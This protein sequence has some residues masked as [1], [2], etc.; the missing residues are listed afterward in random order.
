MELKIGD[1]VLCIKNYIDSDGRIINKIG[2]KYSVINISRFHNNE[3]DI[4]AGINTETIT[5]NVFWLKNQKLNYW[6]DMRENNLIDDFFLYGKK[7]RK[8]KLKKI[9]ESNL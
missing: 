4:V 2:K 7:L 5:T 9:N 6:D 8:E 1:Q 3:I